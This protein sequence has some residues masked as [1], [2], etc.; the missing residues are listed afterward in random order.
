MVSTV[1]GSIPAQRTSVDAVEDA[2]TTTTTKAPPA[3]VVAEPDPRSAVL[4]EVQAQ[5]RQK[6]SAVDASVRAKLDTKLPDDE[7]LAT[8]RAHHPLALGDN[9]PE[10][11]GDVKELQQFLKDKGLYQGE[12]S[13]TFDASTR[14][15]VKQFQRDNGLKVDGVVGQQT[16]GAMLG[17]KLEPGLSML[18]PWAK[19]F[20]HPD[21]APLAPGPAA[22][23]PG[24]PNPSGPNPGG[25]A[26]VVA[27]DNAPPATALRAK[28]L[29]MH[30]QPFLDKLDQVAGRLGVTGDQMLKV[31]NS[32]SGLKTDAVNPNGG[33]T[34]LIQFM[35]ATARGLGTTTE[36]I[37]GMS[38]TQQLDLVEKYYQPFKGKMHSA[39][40]LYAV[41]FYPVALGKSDD[42]VIGGNNAGMI[43]RAN[44][45]FDT[46]KDGVITM[47]NFRDFCRRKFGE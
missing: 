11:Q 16:W 18:A 20:Q 29:Q 32:E 2:T 7:R 12:A 26:P 23:S 8:L 24:G 35:P 41:T 4:P 33:A 46:D 10:V 9:A 31:M 19:G 14:D 3:P 25:T 13:G 30:G 6:A 5:A 22:T 34:G 42:Y 38:A 27:V 36:A 40:D 15:A 21:V 47:G 37:R 45:I 39:T 1:K 28:A 44:P 17:L 43:A